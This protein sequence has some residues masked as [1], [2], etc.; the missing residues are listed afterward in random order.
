MDATATL[1][2]F[3]EIAIAI[4]GFSGVVSAFSGSTGSKSTELDRVRLNMLLQNSLV[5]AFFSL[6]PLVLFSTSLEVERIW[7]V[8]SGCWLIYTAANLFALGRRI[9]RMGPALDG[10]SRPLLSLSFSVSA[11]IVVLQ[12]FNV[13]VLCLAWPHLAALL[14]GLMTASIFFV[15]LVQSLWSNDQPAAHQADESSVD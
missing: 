12:A 11:L 3:A 13:A 10:M 2:V 15:R 14:W 5:T 4:A 1:E 6:L 7:G 8:T 9:R